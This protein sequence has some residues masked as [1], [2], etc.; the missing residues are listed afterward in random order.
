MSWRDHIKVHPAADL[1]PMM[2][3]SEL[4]ELG[5]DI[6]AN[7]LLASLVLHNGKLID[8]RNRLD[9]MELV[10]L[11]HIRLGDRQYR[12]IYYG[13][14]GGHHSGAVNYLP[15]D[16]DP[17]TFVL[18]A[19]IHR[20]HLTAEQKRELIDK[21]LRAKPEESDASIAR[22]T[23]T[24]DKTVAKRRRKLEST[25][26]IPKLEKTVGKDGKKRGRPPK[27]KA[28]LAAPRSEPEPVTPRAT[29][30]AETEI[31]IEQRR[32]EYAA[33]DAE[34]AEVVTGED[35]LEADEYRKAFLLRAADAMAFA[36]YSGEVD[37]EVIATA[38]RVAVKWQDFAQSLKARRGAPDLSIPADLSIP[39]FM[40]RTDAKAA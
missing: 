34:P 7:G 40:R 21:V 15:D 11:K 31:S 23:K 4:R 12:R 5:E 6:K 18:S 36:V 32:A 10:G 14:D 9:A 16:A 26:E 27:R 35:E 29:G 8:G 33:L 3:E 28:G 20:R 22:Q 17:Y 37:A 2:S 39:D 24:S 19:N 30:S 25:S 13:E 38:E 1:F